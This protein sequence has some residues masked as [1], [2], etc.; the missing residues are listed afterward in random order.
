MTKKTGTTSDI[1]L[2]RDDCHSKHPEL[3][4][5]TR[6]RGDTRLMASVECSV[7]PCLSCVARGNRDGGD[8]CSTHF[9]ASC[10]KRE[11]AE[12]STKYTGGHLG[13]HDLSTC[14]QT[15]EC[16]LK[17]P[18]SGYL[19]TS[20]TKNDLSSGSSYTNFGVVGS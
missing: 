9:E 11:E 18:T 6:Y 19:Y 2:H 15:T 5:E 1:Y 13:K 3:R 10:P 4:D 14:W 12:A 17:S 7:E 8:S 16:L 20:K